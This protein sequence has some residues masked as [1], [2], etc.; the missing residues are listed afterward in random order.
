MDQIMKKFY[1]P[2][3]D[4]LMTVFKEG[5]ED[6]YEEIAPGINMEFNKEKEVIGIEVQNAFQ[7]CNIRLTSEKEDLRNTNKVELGLPLQ[8][9]TTR[10]YLA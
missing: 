4:S 9:F 7:P 10:A 1:D 3:T 6:Y 8:S 5:E 2:E